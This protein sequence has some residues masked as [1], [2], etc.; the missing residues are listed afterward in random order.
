MVGLTSD[1][2]HRLAQCSKVIVLYKKALM[3]TI[4]PSTLATSN[5]FY[6]Y[7]FNAMISDVRPALIFSS[8]LQSHNPSL[9]S[10]FSGFKNKL[11]STNEKEF[12]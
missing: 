5:L 1:L 10:E 2:H 12:K 6:A 11:S 8:S 3:N 4:L 7:F 9:N